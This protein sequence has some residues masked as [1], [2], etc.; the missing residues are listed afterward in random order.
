MAGADRAEVDDLGVVVLGHGGHGKRRLLDIQTDVE[1]A[2]L[3]PGCP[4]SV[5]QVST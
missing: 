3:R 2:R 1:C 5:C 4:P